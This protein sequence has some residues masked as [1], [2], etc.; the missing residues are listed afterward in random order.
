MLKGK[1]ASKSTPVG[2]GKGKGKGQ[3]MGGKV[4]AK[5]NK[6]KPTKPTL[7]GITM[8]DIRRLA[9]KGGVKRIARDLY[10]YTRDIMAGF[11]KHLVRDSLVY[12][13]SGGRKTCTGMDVVMAM[14]RQGKSLYGFA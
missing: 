10:P 5:R 12:T 4:A 3:G 13:Q 8:G 6:G 9:R 14:K 11:L 2:K 1:V 7:Q